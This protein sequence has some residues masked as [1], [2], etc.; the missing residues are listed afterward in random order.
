MFW[1]KICQLVKKQYTDNPDR[2][3]DILLFT[4]GYFGQN[5]AFLLEILQTCATPIRKKHD[6]TWFFLNHHYIY[7]FLTSGN[8]TCYSFDIPI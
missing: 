8:S 5:K 1:L 4:L 3:E 2:L 7:S 6:Y